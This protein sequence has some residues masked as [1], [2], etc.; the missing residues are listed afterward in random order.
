MLH[1]RIA[2]QLKIIYLQ[3]Q[4]FEK[5][6]VCFYVVQC[7]CLFETG[8]STCSDK[9]PLSKTLNILLHTRV[10]LERQLNV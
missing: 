5:S 6:D 9:L 8:F 10:T 3:I 4:M 1:I 2:I 7:F